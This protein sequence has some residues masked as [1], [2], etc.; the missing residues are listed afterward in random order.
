MSDF[1]SLYIIGIVVFSVV[2]CLW[3]LWWTKNLK[4][5]DTEVGKT[6]DH[7]FDGIQEYNNPLPRWWL[8]TFYL[9]AIFLVGYLILYP[10]LGKYLGAL[11]WSSQNEL[12][13]TQETANT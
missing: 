6:L 2:A 4:L 5:K 7:N 12:K 11:K 13:A 8:W 9:S 10:G 1:W 3:L